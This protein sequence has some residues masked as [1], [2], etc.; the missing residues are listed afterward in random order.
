MSHIPKKSSFGK[1]NYI[2]EFVDIKYNLQT[3]DIEP[4]ETSLDETAL[5]G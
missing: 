3:K 4:Q 1:S 2:T 5:E